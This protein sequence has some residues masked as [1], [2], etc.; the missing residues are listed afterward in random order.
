MR[1]ALVVVADAHLDRDDDETASFC[2][3][4]NERA[5]D[6]ATLVLL[7]DIFALWIA[8]PKH[9]LAHHRRVLDAVR[10]LRA[11]GVRVLFVEGNRE[12]GVDRWQASEFDTVALSVTEEPWGERRWYLAHGDR[13]D[14]SDWK[15]RVLH[16]VLRSSLVLNTLATVPASWGLS[17][18]D[19][20]ERSLRRRNLRHKTALPRK[21]LEDYAEWLASQHFDGGVIGHIHVAFDMRV[22]TDGVT[23][24]LFVLPDWRSSHSYLRIPRRGEP[25]LLAWRGGRD[26]GVA[27]VAIQ[28][29]PKDCALTLER[30]TELRRGQRVVL[31]SGHGEGTRAGTVLTSDGLHVTVQLASGAPVQIGDRLAPDSRS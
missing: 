26:R 4:L 1:D 20:L 13:L 27:V 9:T 23:R 10:R 24:R 16:A 25:E 2:E 5:S 3:F 30:A 6:A 19:R 12:F 14:P 21:R 11:N 31:H 22:P 15:T 18:G 29:R 28:E 7:G 17:F 8:H